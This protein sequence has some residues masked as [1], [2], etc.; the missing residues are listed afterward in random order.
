MPEKNNRPDTAVRDGAAAWLEEEI[1]A[2]REIDPEAHQ[3][4]QETDQRIRR[5]LKR[6]R[7]RSDLTPFLRG[8]RTAAVAVISAAALFFALSMTVQPVRAAFWEAIVNWYADAVSVHFSADR[9]LPD[10]IREVRYPTYIPAGWRLEAIDVSGTAVHY[11]LTD[12]DGSYVFVLQALADASNESWFDNENIRVDEL[13]VNGSDARLLTHPDGTL[14]LTWTDEYN[15]I[16]TGM[17][18]EASLLVRIAES[19]K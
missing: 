19:M 5:A 2:M 12:D 15:F 11:D 1:R 17:K 18:T 6:D 9:P 4:S 14:T 7:M 8:L 16:L 10:S 13:T 3:I